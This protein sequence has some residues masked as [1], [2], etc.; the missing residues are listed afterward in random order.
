[1]GQS[2]IFWGEPPLDPGAH[3]ALTGPWFAGLGTKS[4]CCVELSW[5]WWEL[6]GRDGC[7]TWCLLTQPLA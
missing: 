6:Q 1:M 3:T 7:R 2:L 5:A 4:L